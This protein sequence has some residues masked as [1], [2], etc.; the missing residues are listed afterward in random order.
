MSHTTLIGTLDINATIT[1]NAVTFTMS[2]M[3]ERASMRERNTKGPMLAKRWSPTA[4]PFPLL[5]QAKLNG[6]RLLASKDGLTSRTGQR[7]GTLP[8]IERALA[9]LFSRYP[10]MVLDGEAYVHGTPLPQIAG[11]ISREQPSTESTA[12]QFHVFDYIAADPF[13]ARIAKLASIVPRDAAA[14]TLTPT[15]ACQHQ[16]D[17]DNHFTDCLAAGYEGQILRDPRAPYV[18]GRTSNL[19]KRKPQP[20]LDDILAA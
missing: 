17:L 10:A 11:A 1:G 4:S 12:I 14:V 19:L 18:R 8:H 3:L 5:A 2:S 16:R 13:E 9:N 7:I 6:W 15:M 20:D